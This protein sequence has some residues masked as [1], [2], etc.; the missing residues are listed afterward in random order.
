MLKL[1]LFKDSRN[2]G[3]NQGISSIARFD[4]VRYGFEHR[5]MCVMYAHGAGG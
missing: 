4:G 1:D 5:R 2:G 3:F